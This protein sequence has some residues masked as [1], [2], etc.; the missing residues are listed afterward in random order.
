MVGLE[1]SK[2]AIRL[3][4]MIT[5]ARLSTHGWFNK[6]RSLICTRQIVRVFD[7]FR[8]RLVAT[9]E[10]R[11]IWILSQK[12][13]IQRPR[14]CLSLLFLDHRFVARRVALWSDVARADALMDGGD[15]KAGAI[16]SVV[17]ITL[18]CHGGRAVRTGCRHRFRL[19]ISWVI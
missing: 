3:K 13:Y 4:R 2:K 15:D 17:W 5:V 9:E 6:H 19:N 1:N 14:I 12:K 8:N 11:G 16:T 10:L 7:S 18:N